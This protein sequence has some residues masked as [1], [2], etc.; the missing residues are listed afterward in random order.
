ML[1]RSLTAAVLIVGLSF[2]ACDGDLSE[3]L[4]DRA[5]LASF[6]NGSSVGTHFPSHSLSGLLFSAI[7]KVYTEQGAGAARAVVN[8]LRRLQEE[9]R[10]TQ[11]ASDREA[12]ASRMLAVRAEELEIVLRVFGGS[13]VETVISAVRSDA[14]AL[15]PLVEAL[16]AGD[17]ARARATDLLAQLGAHLAQA[18]R[19]ASAG[20]GRRALDE[21]TRAAAFSERVGQVLAETRRV[22]GLQ[23]LFDAAVAKLHAVS[24]GEDGGDDV[25]SSLAA[26]NELQREAQQAVRTADRDRAHG[27]LKAERD[28]QIRI[29]LD[30]LGPAAA[31][32]LID[33]AQRGLV[34]LDASLKAARSA[35]RDVSRLSRMS[36][37]AR[38]LLVRAGAALAAG[39]AHTALDLGSHAAGLINSLRLGLGL[40]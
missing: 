19:A 28:E 34:E 6:L 13:I 20:A 2:S 38:D 22:A 14:A 24:T 5:D 40:R 26:Y 1:R 35:G 9:V 39:D 29:V 12:A 17:P 31:H 8:D 16:P 27:A 18:E 30:V 33:A 37:T 3:P 23:E 11:M 4:A 25:R 10:L 21:A 36:A 7:R 15:Q 32:R